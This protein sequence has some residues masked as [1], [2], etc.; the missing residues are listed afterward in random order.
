M[1]MIVSGTALA[2]RAFVFV[3]VHQG[4]FALVIVVVLPLVPIVRCPLR[5]VAVPIVQD[6]PSVL[7]AV[8]TFLSP[9]SAVLVASQTIVAPPVAP[10]GSFSIGLP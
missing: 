6:P 10:A 4:H 1:R 2:V 9:A 8:R 7:Q 3:V 5:T